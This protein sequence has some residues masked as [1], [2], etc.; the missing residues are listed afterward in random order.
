M[1]RSRSM[2]RTSTTTNDMPE[3]TSSHEIATMRLCDSLQDSASRSCETRA[4]DKAN[5]QI[6]LYH[7]VD[8]GEHV[9]ANQAKFDQV[10]NGSRRS[11]G[12]WRGQLT[13]WTTDNW[14]WE[15]G[16][17]TFST[18]LL[19]GIALALLIHDKPA[20]SRLAPRYHYQCL[21]IAPVDLC[22]ICSNRCRN[23]HY[24]TRQVVSI[25]RTAA[26]SIG[27]RVVR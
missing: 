25:C 10:Q 20:R 6:T 24:R 16:S 17:W 1:R 22:D 15:F 2:Q 26:S 21:D 3:R 4:V 5:S 8:G 13:R 7:A 27:V 11:K 23:K 19:M 18:I 14:I 9:R 12:G